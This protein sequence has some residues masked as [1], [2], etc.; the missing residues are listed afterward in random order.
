V[1][2]RDEPANRL[3]VGVADGRAKFVTPALL[4]DGDVMERNLRLVVGAAVA[5]GVALRPHV[6]GHKCLE[7]ARLQ[8]ASGASGLACATLA[9][10]ELM[11]ASGARSLLLTS[12]VVDPGKS[13]RLA[14]L[15]ERVPELI[16]VADDPSNLELL[17]RATTAKPLS[18]LIDLDVGQQRTGI[19]VAALDRV[20]ALR[21][22]IEAAP[23]LRFAGLQAYY[24]HLQGLVDY[25]ER[26]AKAQA[27]QRLV[28]AVVEALTADG[29]RPAI[30]SGGGTGTL[31]ADADAGPFTELQPGSF[32]FLDRQYGRQLLTPDGR[33]W[34]EP[35][36][37]VA[38]R[39]VSVRQPGRVTVDAGMKA[40]STDGGPASLCRPAGVAAEYSFA[41]DEHGCL[42]LETGSS[43]P[44]LGDI[45]E[46]QPAHCDTTVSLHRWLHVVRGGTVEAIWPI[47]ARGYW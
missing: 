33:P 40:I 29:P 21:A 13:E 28:Q 38:G 31:L 19:P 27:Q 6:K 18:V 46:L 34:L 20:L 14:A 39:V 43:S 32:P 36:L 1:S 3:L 7:L 11:A 22:A 47:D 30:V 42:L 23:G 8:L 4:V 12:P 26:A 25:A 10:A 2:Q 37:F 35:A 15:N 9:E 24:G 17:E 16:V 44:R 45:V 41:G 5:G